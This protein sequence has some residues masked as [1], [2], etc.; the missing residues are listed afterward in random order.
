MCQ[1]FIPY[2]TDFLAGKIMFK[3]IIKSVFS[4]Q[5]LNIAHLLYICV[6][7]LFCFL[8]MVSMTSEALMWHRSIT[9]PHDAKLIN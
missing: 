6:V 5:S 3:L 7:D 4:V 9:I 8:F 1:G 2:L